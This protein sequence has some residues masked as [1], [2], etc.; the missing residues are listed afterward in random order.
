MN[1]PP[2]PYDEHNERLRIIMAMNERVAKSMPRVVYDRK[3]DT[4]N[5][6]TEKDGFSWKD[7]KEEKENV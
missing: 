5:L 2:Y 3:N 4:V 6:Y 7:Q 1:L